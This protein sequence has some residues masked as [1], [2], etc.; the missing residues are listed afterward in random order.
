MRK[1]EAAARAK[2]KELQGPAKSSWLSH[3]LFVLDEITTSIA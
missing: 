3:A 2:K 1:L